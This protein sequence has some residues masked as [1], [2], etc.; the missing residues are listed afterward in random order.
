MGSKLGLRRG[1]WGSLRKGKEED[2]RR[3]REIGFRVFLSRFEEC[4]RRFRKASL[5]RK[6][7][8]RRGG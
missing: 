2:L 4:L 8:L 7:G 1:G 6:V 3:D 5:G